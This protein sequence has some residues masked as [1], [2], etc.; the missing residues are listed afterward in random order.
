MEY[1][2]IHQVVDQGNFV[3]TISEDNFAGKP[4]AYYGLFRVKNGK[5]IEPWQVITDI[6]K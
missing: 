4:N 1:H 5:F 2:K 6:P 3:L